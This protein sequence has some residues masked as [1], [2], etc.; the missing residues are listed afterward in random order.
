MMILYD[1]HLLSTKNPFGHVDMLAHGMSTCIDLD[2]HR[3]NDG[4]VLHL[5]G[6]SQRLPQQLLGLHELPTASVQCAP[7]DPQHVQRPV[8]TGKV[9]EDLLLALLGTWERTISVAGLGGSRNC[10]FKGVYH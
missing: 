3:H 8:G 7:R 2:D 9:E 1:S 4:Q 6:L 10:S 5:N